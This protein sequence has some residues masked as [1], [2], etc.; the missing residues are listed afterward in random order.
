MAVKS[1]A[2][3][4]QSRYC[5]SCGCIHTFMPCCTE[6]LIDCINNSGWKDLSEVIRNM[7]DVQADCDGNAG[8]C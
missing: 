8:V 6:A 4:A 3:G 1:V 2:V 7:M 5:G